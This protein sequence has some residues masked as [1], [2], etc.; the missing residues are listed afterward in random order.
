MFLLAGHNDL[1]V[2]TGAASWGAAAASRPIVTYLQL[3]QSIV[4]LSLLW[5]GLM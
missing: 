4:L 2:A 1:L 3:N 5:L